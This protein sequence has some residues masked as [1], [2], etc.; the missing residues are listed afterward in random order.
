MRLA[1]L[2]PLAAVLVACGSSSVTR[3]GGHPPS[4]G[5]SGPPPAWLETRAGR[6]WLGFSSY[7]W[8]HR[9]G[10]SRTGVCADTAAPKCSQQSVPS[11]TV[12][13]GE[14]VRAHLGYDVEQASVEN[15]QSKLKGRTVEWR[16]RRPGLFLL[17]TKGRP[18]DVLYT[19]CAVLP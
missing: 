19:G 10:A 15:T 12:A 11:L 16:I 8:S 5:K 9:E 1:L 13:N 18:G 2:C 17:F 14:R 6:H 4:A 7:C 3:P